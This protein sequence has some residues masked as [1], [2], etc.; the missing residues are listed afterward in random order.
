MEF[1]KDVWVLLALELDNP[2]L[3]KLCESNSS[4]NKN[5]CGND[6]FWY[7]KILKEYPQP[8]YDEYKKKDDT[9]FKEK[10]ITLQRG[11]DLYQEAKK[12]KPVK[13]VGFQKPYFFAKPQYIEFFKLGDFGDIRIPGKGESISI[14]SA[15]MPLL[16]AGMVNIIIL[17]KL[18]RRYFKKNNLIT[19]EKW[20]RS[21]A[22]MNKYFGDV[23][24][25]NDGIDRNKINKPDINRL[26]AGMISEKVP[27][28]TDNDYTNFNMIYLV[29]NLLKQDV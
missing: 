16:E 28:P 10:Y 6:F 18:L 5:V 12:L 1:G 29:M 9:I 7:N 3:I 11:K 22:L 20:A 26:A 21:D 14:K 24:S 17:A 19:E 8:Y 2:S 4:V 15:I 25:K 27:L 13:L 23:F